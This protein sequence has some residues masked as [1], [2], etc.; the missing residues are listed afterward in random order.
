M[1]SAS[2]SSFFIIVSSIYLFC[3]DF[4]GEYGL[5]LIYNTK[6]ILYVSI[7]MFIVANFA[8]MLDNYIERISK[9][10]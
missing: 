4:E 9:K 1:K 2:I 8:K 6:A 7:A 3:G 10:K 5:E